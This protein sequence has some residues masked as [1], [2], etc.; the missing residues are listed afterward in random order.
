MIAPVLYQSIENDG[1]EGGFSE[2]FPDIFGCGIFK[3][4][5]DHEKLKNPF[6]RSIAP[7]TTDFALSIFDENADLILSMTEETVFFALFSLSENADLML[8][9][10][11]RS[12]YSPYS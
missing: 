9:S 10:F 5:R 7:D 6:I 2:N 8:S 12:M 4:G 1:T 3:C 11:P